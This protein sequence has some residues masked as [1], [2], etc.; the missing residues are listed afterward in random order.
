MPIVRREA[1]LALVTLMLKATRLSGAFSDH[2]WRPVQELQAAL[3]QCS[4]ALGLAMQKKVQ[5]KM[6]TIWSGISDIILLVNP[7]D[8]FSEKEHRPLHSFLAGAR[9]DLQC[10][11]AVDGG[12]LG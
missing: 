3:E 4:R 7:C 8:I 5:S 6:H 1:A 10:A 11:E 12:R 2:H 9:T